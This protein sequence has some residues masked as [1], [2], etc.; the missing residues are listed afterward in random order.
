MNDSLRRN[1]REWQEQVLRLQ[2]QREER[3]K[4]IVDLKA[5]IERGRSAP[6]IVFIRAEQQP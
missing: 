4:E 1:Q 5:R 6:A 3:D 2:G